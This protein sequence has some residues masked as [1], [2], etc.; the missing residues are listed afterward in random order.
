M[1]V[2][3]VPME[4]LALV[5]AAALSRPVADG[6]LR[7]VLSASASNMVVPTVLWRA[8]PEANC[9]LHSTLSPAITFPPNILFAIPMYLRAVHAALD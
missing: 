1:T 5:M 3:M 9:S 4:P 8:I 2:A 7:I 6:G